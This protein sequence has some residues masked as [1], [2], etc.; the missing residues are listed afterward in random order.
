MKKENKTRRNNHISEINWKETIKNYIILIIGLFIMSFGVALSVISDL[1]TTPI[2]CIPNVLKYAVPLS[3]GMIT[4]IFNFLLI[5]IQVLILKSE[6]QRKQWMQIVVTIIFGYFID[7]ALYILTPIEPTNYISQWILCIISCFIIA[8]GVYFEVISNA[9]VLPG[10][11]VSLA[12]RHVTHIDFGKLKTG[13]D[14]S[15]V[16]IGAILSLLLYGTFKGIGLGTI[17]AGIVVGYIVRG[18]KQI[19]GKILEKN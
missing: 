13:F 19:I 5:I 4:I 7:Y 8:L 9:I 14:T 1:G 3:L 6:F 2:S 12:V 16:I 15:N 18:Y 10:E 11:G 17:F